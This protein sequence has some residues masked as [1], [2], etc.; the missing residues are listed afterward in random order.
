MKKGLA[1]SM[2]D[3]HTLSTLRSL[4]S[5]LMSDVFT[6]SRRSM[7]WSSTR[8]SRKRRLRAGITRNLITS[9]SKSMSLN[10]DEMKI[11]Y[12]RQETGELI[13]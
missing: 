11:L 5:S 12:L 8:R 2:Q 13:V 10:V 4:S 3:V 9:L 1:L 7:A 6:P